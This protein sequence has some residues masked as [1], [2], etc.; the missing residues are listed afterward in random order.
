MKLLM[1]CETFQA[2]LAVYLF[3]VLPVNAFSET[4]S[5]LIYVKNEYPFGYCIDTLLEECREEIESVKR[6]TVQRERI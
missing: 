4:V 2:C 3:V 6:F 1:D 5:T